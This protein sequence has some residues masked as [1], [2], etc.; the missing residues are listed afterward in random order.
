MIKK[1]TADKIHNVWWE[2]TKKNKKYSYSHNICIFIWVA[3]FE[4]TFE[5][6]FD[7]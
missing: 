1:N 6:I 4:F 7:K 2:L 5:N 3:L